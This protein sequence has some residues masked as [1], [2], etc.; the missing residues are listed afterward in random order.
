MSDGEGLHCSTWQDTALVRIV[1]VGVDAHSRGAKTVVR[2]TK[3]KQRDGTYRR[4]VN[5]PTEAIMY[6]AGMGGV[7][8]FDHMNGG[9]YG[10]AGVVKTHN[11]PALFAIGM[12]GKAATNSLIAATNCTRNLK[13][14]KHYEQ[15]QQ[16]HAVSVCM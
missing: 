16:L 2:K 9:R 8:A 5:A 4:E 6:G 7:D 12:V 14:L 10:L 1:S 3:V 15:Y 13:N 11:W